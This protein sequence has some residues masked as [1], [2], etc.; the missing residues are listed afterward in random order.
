MIVAKF[1]YQVS[2]HRC[3]RGSSTISA[4]HEPVIPTSGVN[5]LLVRVTVL[6]KTPTHP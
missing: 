4:K 5:R 3:D 1:A 2:R 6:Q